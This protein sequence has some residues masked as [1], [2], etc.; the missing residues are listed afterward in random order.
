M[1]IVAF[2]LPVNIFLRRVL[3][4]RIMLP[5]QLSSRLLLA[6]RFLRSRCTAGDVGRSFYSDDEKTVR[7]YNEMQ[8]ADWWWDTQKC[9]PPDAIVIPIILIGASPQH[10][11]DQHAGDG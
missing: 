4:S 8:T 9:L 5:F 11:T 1:R 6:R 3:V 2:P 7:I 10:S